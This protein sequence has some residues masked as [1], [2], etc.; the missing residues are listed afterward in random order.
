VALTSRGWRE[1]REQAQKAHPVRYWLA[2][3]GLDFLQSVIKFVPDQLYAIKYYVN[4]RWVSKTHA[5]TA[6]PSDIPRGEWRDVGWRF[7]PCLFNELRDY[8]EVELAWWHVAWAD[9]EQKA[10]YNVP[11]WATG[12]WR[13]RTWRCPQAGLD[14][15]EWQMTLQQDWRSED[16]PERELPSPQAETAREILALYKWWTEVYP[17]RPDPHEASGW[18]E[19]CDRRRQQGDLFDFEDRTPEEHQEANR[20]LDLTRSIEEQQEQE[21]EEMMIRLIRVRKALWT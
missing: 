1:W 21:D 10:K 12:W 14:N 16:D 13:W 3:D 11:W 19:L 6:S 2:E 20:I 17:N 7:L 5:L 9:A 8:V 18:S 15:L 4:N